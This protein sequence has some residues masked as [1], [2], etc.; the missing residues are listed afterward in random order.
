MFN[1]N[2][3][4]KLEEAY[5]IQEQNL[6]EY[7]EQQDQII[8][9]ILSQE[10]LVPHPVWN[11]ILGQNDKNDKNDE[12]GE[13]PEIEENEEIQQKVYTKESF[14]DFMRCLL[15]IHLRN[16]NYKIPE[17]DIPKPPEEPE[18]KEPETKEPEKPEGETDPEAP[19][20][21]LT[22]V[23]K[24]VGSLLIPV[25]KPKYVIPE[26]TPLEAE[27][28]QAQKKLK[29]NYGSG[30]DYG[31]FDGFVRYQFSLNREISRVELAKLEW[32]EHNK[33]EKKR[34]DQEAEQ[35]EKEQYESDLLYQGR[36]YILDE[37]KESD[38]KALLQKEEFEL[39]QKEKEDEDY[40]EKYYGDG[41]KKDYVTYPV[42]D[43]DVR[44]FALQKFCGM[45]PGKKIGLINYVN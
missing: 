38:A 7:Y 30:Y 42:K 9:E 16:N 15:L 32:E 33:D 23:L 5:A 17:E 11:L 34:L 14:D 40:I 8:S 27:L 44:N 43:A 24:S 10:D 45:I 31:D 25:D 29:I 12:N 28:V 2:V 39:K 36:L 35:L 3:R 20:K 13:N 18:T 22:K 26:I 37:K 41:Y 21:N 6:W 1:E 4:A 19:E